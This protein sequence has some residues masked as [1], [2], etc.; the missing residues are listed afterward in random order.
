MRQ[1][2]GIRTVLRFRQK[3]KSASRS[4][5]PR[6]IAAIC[7]RIKDAFKGRKLQKFVFFVFHAFPG[8]YINFAGPTTPNT[9]V[10]GEHQNMKKTVG[11][12]S[13]F[14]ANNGLVNTGGARH[15]GYVLPSTQGGGSPPKSARIEPGR[16]RKM[17]P[18]VD[19]KPI[20]I[21]SSKR[22]FLC[23]KMPR[24]QKKCSHIPGGME[25]MRTM[26]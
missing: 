26:R 21:C 11:D 17:R 2:S 13:R 25:L 3:H 19:K 9:R 16:V 23:L 5:G 24:S 14:H 1:A 7:K 22:I 15:E 4:F 6:Q 20:P 10:C 8:N 12:F 18:V